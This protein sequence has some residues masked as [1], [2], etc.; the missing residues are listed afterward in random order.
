MTRDCRNCKYATSL[1]TCKIGLTRAIEC[2][3]RNL[4]YY[5]RVEYDN[6]KSGKKTGREK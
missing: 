3:C 2:L 5:E 4:K 1:G 6:D